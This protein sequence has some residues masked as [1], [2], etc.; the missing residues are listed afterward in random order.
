MGAVAIDRANTAR[1]NI[2]LRGNNR[3]RGSLNNDLIALLFHIHAVGD[4][5]K[6]KMALFLFPGVLKIDF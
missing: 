1:Q 5:R 3:V 4:E 2:I 6:T